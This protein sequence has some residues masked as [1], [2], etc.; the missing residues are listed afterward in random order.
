MKI[1]IIED[2]PSLRELIQRS[3]EKERYVVEAAADFQSGLR[4][5]EDYDYDCVL[6]DIMLPDGNGL[7]LLEQLKKMHKR[8]NVIIISAKDS[9]DD[10]VLGLELGADDYLPKPFH[11]AE[12]NAR[13]KSVIRRQRRDG[14]MDIRLANIR[15]VPDTFQVFVDDK[16]IELNRKEYD[17]LLYFANR[18]GRLVNKNTLAE[19]VWGDHIDQVDNFDFIYAQIKNLRKKLKDAGALAE[20]KAVYGFGYKMSVE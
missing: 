6:L 2:E 5:I 15:I 13:I 14:E 20:L 19:S 16:E 17:I 9:L 8:E 11:L 18:P 3:L 7:N 4:K 1:L 10:K 12:L